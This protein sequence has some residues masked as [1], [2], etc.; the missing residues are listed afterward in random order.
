VGKHEFV[1]GLDYAVGDIG[2]AGLSGSVIIE[3]QPAVFVDLARADGEIAGDCF[4]GM[5]GVEIDHVGCVIGQ[6]FE[7]EGA[8]GGDQ[9]D[10]AG[11]AFGGEA[12]TVEIGVGF[13]TEQGGGILAPQGGLLMQIEDVDGDEFA[14][15]ADIEDF[16]AEVAKCHTD[17]DNHPAFRD[18][19][20]DIGAIGQ[21]AGICQQAGR[22]FGVTAVVEDRTAIRYPAI[23]VGT[24]DGEA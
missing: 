22:E 8:V 23:H 9:F 24:P 17:L 10:L 19:R 7:G 11:L 21:D 12:V 16:A 6:G 2:E 18:Q 5:F 4:V 13:A 1:T 14:G 20:Q 15:L 3:D